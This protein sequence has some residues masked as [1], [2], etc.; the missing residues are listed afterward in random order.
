MN[1]AAAIKTR[2]RD[3]A[4]AHDLDPDLM[5]A[6]AKVESGMRYEPVRYE[7]GY[8]W[9][10]HVPSVAANLGIST[11]TERALQSMS[12]GPLQVMGAVCREYG[13]IGHLSLLPSLPDLAIKYGCQHMKNLMRRFGSDEGALSAAYNAGSPRKNRTGCYEN[14]PYV[15]KVH[16]ALIAIRSGTGA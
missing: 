11:D 14:Q 1:V 7:A 15:D 8:R 16:R 3:C 5:E 10:W 13:Y 6:I 9:F 2:V 12:Y 4:I